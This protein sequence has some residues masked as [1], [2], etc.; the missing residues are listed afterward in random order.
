MARWTFALPLAV[1]LALAACHAPVSEETATDEAPVVSLGG[2]HGDGLPPRTLVLTYDDGPDEHTLEVARYLASQ[3]IHA[4]FF[5]NGRRYQNTVT[6]ACD[7]GHEQAV[8]ASPALYPESLV[9]EIVALG[10]RVGNHSEDHCELTHQSTSAGVVFELAATQALLDRH[11]TSGPA[12]FRPPYGLWDSRTTNAAHGEPSL[13]KLVGPVFWDVDGGDWDCWANAMSIDA[14]GQR[15]LDAVHARPQQNGIVLMHDRPE[16]NV[17]YAGPLLLTRWL[18][19]RLVAEG[20]QFASID[21]VP[22][23]I[24]K[25]PPP[26]WFG[27]VSLRSTGTDFSDQRGFDAANSYHESLRFGDVD[28]DGVADA[29]AREATGIVCARGTAT[30][31]A[32]AT[33]WLATDFTNAAGWLPDRYGTTLQLA[34]IDGD[35]KADLCGRGGAGIMCASASS[36][37]RAFDSPFIRTRAGDFGD[38]DGFSTSPS[39]YGSIRFADVNGDGF[40]DV[41]GRAPAG[42]TCAL[43]RKDGTFARRTAWLSTEFT[44][45][46][47]W[48]PSH[49]GATLQLGDVNGDH[50]ADVCGRGAA[51]V[52]CAVAN[53]AGDGFVAP[54]MWLADFTD[55]A[56]WSALPYA[57]SLRLGD[58]DGDG[59]ADI[60]ARGPG[61]LRCAR[62]N[63]SGFDAAAWAL[64]SDFRDDLGWAAPAYATTIRF[65]DANS[66]GKADVCGR[67]GAGILCALAR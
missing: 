10:H 15:Y 20:F 13:D 37:G 18:V 66:D 39:T 29:C 34:D 12:L 48:A 5:Q 50:R 61:G 1:V 26:S 2:I 4:T 7:D 23:V 43:N 60:C 40:A 57:S 35:G 9:D 32:A 42:V 21:D 56:G 65:V 49:Y 53:S 33:S 51:G 55:A 59:R 63:G 54:A 19:E 41:C 27:A 24:A 6:R 64:T 17:G 25:P 28:G 44:D 45:A 46:L 31:F 30:G 52:R 22:G 62:S 16:F 14:C 3:S 38:A 67:G 11:V 47:G 58:V 36:S 8:V